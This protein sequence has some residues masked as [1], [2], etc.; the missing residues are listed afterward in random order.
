MAQPAGAAE[1]HWRAGEEKLFEAMY[2][3]FPNAPEKSDEVMLS[4]LTNAK[5]RGA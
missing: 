3:L 2:L 4:A 1:S 5:V